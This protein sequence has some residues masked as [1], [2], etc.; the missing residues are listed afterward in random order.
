[1]GVICCGGLTIFEIAILI[2]PTAT[3]IA[4]YLFWKRVR[5]NSK[6]YWWLW[7]S[8]IIVLFIVGLL[9]WEPN[10]EISQFGSGLIV[11]SSIWFNG[12]V[13]ALTIKRGKLRFWFVPIAVLLALFSVFCC[14]IFLAATQ[15]IW[16]M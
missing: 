11:S 2:F 9:V 16:G 8:I 12:I 5:Y 15:Q 10:H 14:F 7:L 3:L 1:M 13:G 4:V 6:V